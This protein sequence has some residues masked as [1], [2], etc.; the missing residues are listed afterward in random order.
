MQTK[1]RH[2]GYVLID[3]RA[4]PGIT[5]HFVHQSGSKGIG[6]PAVGEGKMLE[7]STIT[8][9]HCQRGVILNPQRSHTREWCSKCDHYLCDGCG[10]IKRVDGQCRNLNQ[11]FDKLQEQAFQRGIIHG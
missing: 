7:A 4:S 5:P 9:A 3:N 8:C 1:R 11:L 6:V 10:L 2:E